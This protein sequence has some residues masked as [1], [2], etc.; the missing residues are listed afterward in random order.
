MVFK[1]RLSASV[2]MCKHLYSRL[3]NYEAAGKKKKHTSYNLRN[4]P[5]EKVVQKLEVGDLP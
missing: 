3:Y 1:T 2:L 5:L 4:I